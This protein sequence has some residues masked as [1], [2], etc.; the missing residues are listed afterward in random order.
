MRNSFIYRVVFV[1][2][3]KHESSRARR[4]K[5]KETAEVAMNKFIAK[6]TTKVKVAEVYQTV[7]ALEALLKF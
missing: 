5:T 4:Y 6:Q 7:P 3:T 1:D 2:G